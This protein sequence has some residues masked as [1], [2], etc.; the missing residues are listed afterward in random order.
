MLDLV[1]PRLRPRAE[2]DDA[3]RA[4]IEAGA[5]EIEDVVNVGSVRA[6][7]RLGVHDQMTCR[8]CGARIAIA[9]VTSHG[10]L[11]GDCLA[12]LTGDPTTR[13]R[14]QQLSRVIHGMSL[15]ADARFRLRTYLGDGRPDPRKVAIDRLCAN[16]ERCVYVHNGPRYEVLMVME[17]VA[18]LLGYEPGVWEDE[19]GETVV[20][21]RYVIATSSLTVR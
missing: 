4:A 9:Y 5:F 11:G 17:R 16:Y 15:G 1:K 8:R 20:N 13:R 19:R 3:I 10:P 14:L 12:T 6:C 7:E 2:F 21:V 18:A